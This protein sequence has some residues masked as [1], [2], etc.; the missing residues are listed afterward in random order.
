MLKLRSYLAGLGVYLAVKRGP[1]KL[2]LIDIYMRYIKSK[3]IG[4]LKLHPEANYNTL[5]KDTVK[6]YNDT[7]RCKILTFQRDR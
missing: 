4:Y 6:G 5:L 2:G 3:I 1:L 7:Y